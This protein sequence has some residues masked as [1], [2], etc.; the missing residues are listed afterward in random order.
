M[1]LPASHH[2]V[3]YLGRWHF[4]SNYAITTAPGAQMEIAFRGSF[5]VLHFDLTMN[6]HPYPHL[7]LSLDNGPRFEVP[8]DRVIRVETAE[9]GNHVLHLV[10]KGSMEVLNRWQGPLVGKIALSGAETEC[11]GLLPEDRRP[12]LEFL[13]D[14][15]TEGV[16]VD[17]D[18]KFSS[19]DQ[20]NRPNQD[21]ST[22]TYAWLTAQMLGC[23]PLIMGYGG[24]GVTRGGCGG[25]PKAALA[26]PY[27]MEGSVKNAEKP[28]SIIVN[29]GANDLANGEAAYIEQY[30]QLLKVVRKHNPGIRIVV[31]SA[32]CGVYPKALEALVKRWNDEQNDEIV[33]IDSTG[34]IS[35]EPL[36]PNREG[37]YAIA[38]QL[39]PLLEKL[40]WPC[41]L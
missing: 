4:D 31:L 6:L 37:H 21:D 24:I 12:I 26:Y 19:P 3:R 14:S 13:G 9:A 32:F 20:F 7:W 41:V 22:A 36:H 35:A 16:L 8:L 1:F 5:I 29:Y 40:L 17:S 2:A 18:Y 38:K 23:R 15:I 34:W 39:A 27:N 11:D 30:E 33:F 10:F 25:V 28:A